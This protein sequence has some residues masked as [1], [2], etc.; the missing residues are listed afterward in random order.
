MW[1][2]K[3]NYFL[4]YDVID[5]R[6]YSTDGQWVKENELIWWRDKYNFTSIRIMAPLWLILIKFIE[7]IVIRI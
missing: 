1:K 5:I 6:S 7:R 3:D 2:I 4:R